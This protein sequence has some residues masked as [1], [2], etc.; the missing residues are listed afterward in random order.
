MMQMPSRLPLKRI[1]QPIFKTILIDRWPWRALIIVTSLVAAALG[2]VAA[3]FQKYFI[4]S[5]S[6]NYSATEK[7]Q[8]YFMLGSF[9]C[10]VFASLFTQMN[11]Y[12][13]L[14]ESLFSQRKLAQRLY[15]QSLTLKSE[16]LEKKTVGEMVALY[17]TDV[18][19]ST[20]LLEQ[21]LP[22]GASTFFPLILTPFAL[23]YLV[24]TPLLETCVLVVVVAL[25]NTALAFKQ[26]R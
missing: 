13:G 16:S 20:I 10:F 26:S 9:V 23:V 22:Y 5:L 6:G 17:A 2:L 8:V 1:N 12:W 7:Q 14:R 4:D 21:T 3:G 25:V 19:A 11:N 15:D 18:P 24:G